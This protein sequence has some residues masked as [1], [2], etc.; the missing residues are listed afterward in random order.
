[1]LYNKETFS[2]QKGEAVKLTTKMKNDKPKVILHVVPISQR[3]T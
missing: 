2:M 1:M 3:K